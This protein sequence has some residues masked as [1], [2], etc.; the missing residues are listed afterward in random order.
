MDSILRASSKDNNLKTVTIRLEDV[1]SSKVDLPATSAKKEAFG[2][3]DRNLAASSLA[4]P[5]ASTSGSSAVA[6]EPRSGYTANDIAIEIESEGGSVYHSFVS[7]EQPVVEIPSIEATSANDILPE[8]AAESASI[9]QTERDRRQQS[10]A[11]WWYNINDGMRNLAPHRLW[12]EKS[13]SCT[14]IN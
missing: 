9:E 11:S 3:A 12:L 5:S 8:A 14:C 10:D 1:W 13:P 6:K 2:T 7:A 4:A